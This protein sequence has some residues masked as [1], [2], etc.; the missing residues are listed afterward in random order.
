MPQEAAGEVATL[1]IL[2]PIQERRRHINHLRALVGQD[3]RLNFRSLIGHGMEMM[4]RAC[5]PLIRPW[6][7]AKPIWTRVYFSWAKPVSAAK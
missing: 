3:D 1:N 5:Q 6:L 4:M 2:Q 7:K